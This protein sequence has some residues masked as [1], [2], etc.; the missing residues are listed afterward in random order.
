MVQLCA[1]KCEYVK[2][3][4]LGVVFTNLRVQVPNS[5]P[6]D[7]HFR[8]QRPKKPIVDQIWCSPVIIQQNP[9]FDWSI[10]SVLKNKYT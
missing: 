4:F 10:M 3:P 1:L 2:N 7:P 8:V 5:L 6:N 9:Y